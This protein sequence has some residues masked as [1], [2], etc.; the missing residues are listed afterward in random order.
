MSCCTYNAIV[1]SLV[2]R[3][4]SFFFALITFPVEV[5]LY[6]SSVTEIMLLIPGPPSLSCD[7]VPSLS[8]LNYD[9][10]NRELW[11]TLY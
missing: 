3:I 9:N 6:L 10:Y 5:R 8:L 2:G 4:I 7:N 11:N 1:T